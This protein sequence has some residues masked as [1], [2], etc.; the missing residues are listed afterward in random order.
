MFL[1]SLIVY[2]VSKNDKLHVGLDFMHQKH[3]HIST[4]AYNTF[5]VVFTLLPT[6]KGPKQAIA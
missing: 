4:L 2:L 3:S 5:M 6:H 1:S